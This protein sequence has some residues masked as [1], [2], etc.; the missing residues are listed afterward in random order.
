MASI[1]SVARVTVT[2]KTKN[3]DYGYKLHIEG[4]VM[5]EV[6][7]G[8]GV[9]GTEMVVE[10]L[11]FNTPARAKFLKKPKSEEN[12]VT[13][14]IQRLA[15]ANPNVAFTYTAND[16]LVMMDFGLGLDDTVF[17]IYGKEFLNEMFF[18]RKD[19]KDISLHGYISNVTFTK[20]NRTYQTVILNGRYIVNQTISMAI[21]NAYQY[22]F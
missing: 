7:V 8:A 11:F 21:A 10:N 2:T 13:D 1:A 22:A 19:T 14:V 5:G 16:K 3:D 9:K 6:T 4:G 12:D 17:G 15:I 18:V 20:S